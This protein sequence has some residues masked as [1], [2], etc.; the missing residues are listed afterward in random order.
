MDFHEIDW[1]IVFWFNLNTPFI[2]IILLSLL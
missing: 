2:H 1:W